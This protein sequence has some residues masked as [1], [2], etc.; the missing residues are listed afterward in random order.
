MEVKATFLKGEIERMIRDY[1]E[2]RNHH[3]ISI[4]LEGEKI[5][6]TFSMPGLL[7]PEPTINS[8]YWK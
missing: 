4:N 3:P 8:S 1:L 6:V 5:H 7:P 2:K